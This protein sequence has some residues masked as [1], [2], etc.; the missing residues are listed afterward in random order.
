MAIVK[1]IKNSCALRRAYKKRAAVLPRHQVRADGADPA[2]YCTGA[3]VN[4]MKK[5]DQ[6]EK[7]LLG[8]GAGKGAADC[9]C[10]GATAD[11]SGCAAC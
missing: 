6:R 11:G 9:C 4:A 5:P 3:P 2:D 1:D 10:A 7:V 8:S